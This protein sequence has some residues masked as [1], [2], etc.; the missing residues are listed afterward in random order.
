MCAALYL[1]EAGGGGAGAA[2]D[3]A[4]AAPV[5]KRPMLYL[6]FRV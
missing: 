5:F 3:P 6:A 4:P 2:A 1:S